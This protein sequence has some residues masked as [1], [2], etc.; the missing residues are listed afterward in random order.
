[1]PENQDRQAGIE[2]TPEMIEAGAAALAGWEND[3]DSKLEA[4][5]RIYSAMRDIDKP[6]TI[7]P[8]G[9]PPL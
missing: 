2:V 6:R 8:I 7:E 3:A 1:M 4:V 9:S 5:V